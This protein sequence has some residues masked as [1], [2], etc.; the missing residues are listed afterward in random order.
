MIT[1]EEKYRKAG[2]I[3]SQAGGTPLPVDDTA[4]IKIAAKRIAW[5]KFFNSGQTC[6]T[7]NYACVNVLRSIMARPKRRAPSL[8]PLHGSSTRKASIALKRSMR[9]LSSAVPKPRSE[10]FLMRRIST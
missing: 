6:I 4:D 9:I 2:E 7:A 3:I 10:V 1:A 5:G 8:N